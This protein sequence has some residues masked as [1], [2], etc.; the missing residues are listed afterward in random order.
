M[1]IVLAVI[2]IKISTTHLLHFIIAVFF[3]YNSIMKIEALMSKRYIDYIGKN[4]NSL[5][6]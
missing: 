5:L 2:Q 4:I 3:K 6:N 1:K